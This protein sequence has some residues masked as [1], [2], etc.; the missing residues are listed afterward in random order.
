M[1]EAKKQTAKEPFYKLHVAIAE[2]AD[3][4]SNAKMAYS[5]I[6]DAMRQKG[7]SYPGQERIASLIGASVST[8]GRAVKELERHGLLQVDRRHLG[9]FT[10]YRLPRSPVNMT[11][12]TE[13]LTG[14]NDVRHPSKCHVTPVK[15]TGGSIPSLLTD[16]RNR[17]KKQTP[18]R[19]KKVAPK[20]SRKRDVIWDA[21]EAE[22]YPSGVPRSQAAAFKLIVMDYESVGATPAEIKIRAKRYREGWPSAACTARALV[23]HWD[24]F[25]E[26]VSKRDNEPARV[27]GPA[28]KYDNLQIRRSREA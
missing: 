5:V 8:V 25:S 14:Q 7:E 24:Q 18:A 22:F 12:Q 28:G 19:K 11:G 9:K 26:D 16:E 21:V 10:M 6:R 23:K 15:M 4:G 13:C 17:R 3:I 27:R 1:A 2:R 20:K